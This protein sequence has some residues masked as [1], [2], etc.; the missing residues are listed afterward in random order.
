MSH[1]QFKL[2]FN[3]DTFNLK[4]YCLHVIFICLCPLTTHFFFLGV[5]PA[6][7]SIE[8]V[9]RMLHYF[10]TE[11][12]TFFSVVWERQTVRDKKDIV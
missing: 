3:F 9:K 12:H 5:I 11:F 2:F 1:L 10:E 4:K 7:F 6:G 8:F